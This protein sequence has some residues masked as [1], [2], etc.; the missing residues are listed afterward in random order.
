[1][2]YFIADLFSV[3]HK[4]QKQWRRFEETKF[5]MRVSLSASSH[6]LPET[7]QY[8]KNHRIVKKRFRNVG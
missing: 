4:S 2:K 3:G 6:S 8:I 7:V 5:C 1:M